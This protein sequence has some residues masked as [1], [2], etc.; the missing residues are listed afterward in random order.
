MKLGRFA[1]IASAARPTEFVYPFTRLTGYFKPEHVSENATGTF[2]VVIS[3]A[4]KLAKIIRD[5]Q[6]QSDSALTPETTLQAF[7]ETST[8]DLS[9]ETT[10][11]AYENQ[12]TTK[13]A[14]DGH[15]LFEKRGS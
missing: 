6:I 12:W 2:S 9:L 8:A 4:E 10:L 13:L 7:L 11:L 3:R 1:F 15:W 14:Q 5:E